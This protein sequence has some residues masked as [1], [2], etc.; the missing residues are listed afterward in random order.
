MVTVCMENG[1]IQKVFQRESFEKI[2][3][4]YSLCVKIFNIPCVEKYALWN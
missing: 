3:A 2:N 1:I 4:I